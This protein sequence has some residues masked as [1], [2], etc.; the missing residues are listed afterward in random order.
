ML[1]DEYIT[2]QTLHDVTRFE[3]CWTKS[4]DSN[5]NKTCFSFVLSETDLIELRWNSG[6]K[7]SFN[8]LVWEFLSR[9]VFKGSP[10]LLT[11]P[12]LFQNHHLV[13]TNTALH[14][15]ATRQE[16]L[17]QCKD[18]SY[19]QKAIQM[20]YKTTQLYLASVTLQTDWWLV[21][22]ALT[23]WWPLTGQAANSTFWCHLT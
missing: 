23:R 8:R 14:H 21:I 7:M 17:Q 5:Q 22:G 15:R 18:I 19:L 10:Q 20:V 9:L 2:G 1:I 4:T 3:P 16:R 11:Q 13:N 6:D 12:A